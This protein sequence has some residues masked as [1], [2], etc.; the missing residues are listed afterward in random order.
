MYIPGLGDPATSAN[1]PGGTRSSSAAPSGAEHRSS[2][3]QKGAEEKPGWLPPPSSQAPPFRPPPPAARAAPR[4]E[5][6]L[7]AEDAAFSPG[8]TSLTLCLPQ[9]RGEP[10]RTEAGVERAGGASARSR[11]TPIQPGL[12]LR[13]PLHL[14][15]AQR[16]ADPQPVGSG[17]A[18]P[19]VGPG[20]SDEESCRQGSSEFAPHRGMWP[21]RSALPC[22]GE[23][24]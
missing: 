22:P 7:R 14:S 4:W 2:A 6:A 9:L 8:P 11:V 3:A 19:T 23:S 15:R 21:P 18:P 5:A 13:S 24:R 10:G 20:R 17:R 1:F 12:S 16:D